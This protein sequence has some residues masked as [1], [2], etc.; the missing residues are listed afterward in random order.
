LIDIIWGE[1]W[2]I[3]LNSHNCF[4][5]NGGK[6]LKRIA[7]S[8]LI[9][10]IL[11]TIVSAVPDSVVAGPYK[12]S[13]DIGEPENYKIIVGDPQEV[14]QLNGEK[15]TEYRIT[16]LNYTGYR[17]ATILI[18]ELGTKIPTIAGSD[19]ELA[20]RSLEGND[21]RLSN[22]Q[23]ASREIDGSSGAVASAIQKFDTDVYIEGYHAIYPSPID[24]ASVVVEI[25]S[26]FP[27]NEGTLNLLKTI[28]VEKVS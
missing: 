17:G 16:I 28:H 11:S 13:F 8:V 12:V 2:A 19:W 9:V 26:F 6:K 21:P 25:L 23:S 22:F 3:T 10:L 14:E 1:K 27:W 20:L 24:P 4:S 18:R 7:L 15:Q 5:S